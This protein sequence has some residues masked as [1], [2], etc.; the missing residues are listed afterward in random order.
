MFKRSPDTSYLGAD[1]TIQVLAPEIAAEA[2]PGQFVQIRVAEPDIN[3]PLLARPISIYR[4]DRFEGVLP[5]SL[6]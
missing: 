1:I 5:L 6:K 2:K 4:I 3:D